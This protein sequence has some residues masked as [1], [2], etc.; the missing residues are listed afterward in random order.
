LEDLLPSAASRAWLDVAR[1][2]GLFDGLAALL[3]RRGAARARALLRSL[4]LSVSA[5]LRRWRK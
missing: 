5:R 2:T 3:G 1:E 4:P